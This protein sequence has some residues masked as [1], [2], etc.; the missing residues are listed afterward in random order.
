MR[1]LHRSWIKRELVELPELAAMAEPLVG[2]GFQ[3]DLEC[4][5]E[6]LAIVVTGHPEDFVV[7]FG[8]ARADA[9]FQSSARN[10]I[11]H[12]VVFGTMERMAQ[13]EDR[14]ARTEMDFRRARRR[15]RKQHR[16]IGDQSAI[17]EKVVFIEQ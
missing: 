10:R 14:D 2:P 12:G 3:Y 13:R 11:D 4:F 9:E 16:G 1:F 15:R 5:V 8:I 7:H 6:T 17:T